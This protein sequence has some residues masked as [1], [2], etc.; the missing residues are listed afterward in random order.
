MRKAFEG[1]DMQRV[2]VSVPLRVGPAEKIRGTDC[3]EF[4]IFHPARFFHIIKTDERFIDR[5]KCVEISRLTSNTGYCLQPSIAS[6]AWVM[7]IFPAR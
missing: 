7:L 2:N 1:L 4:L 3:P 5:T 6:P